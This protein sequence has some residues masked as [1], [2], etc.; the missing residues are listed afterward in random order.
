[1]YHLNITLN[2][3]MKKLA[4]IAASVAMTLAPFASQAATTNSFSPGDLIKGSGAAVYYF[5]AD[6]HR[7][8]FPNA[9]TYFTWYKDFSGVKQIPDSMLASLPLA[10]QNVTYRPGRKM[11]KITTDPSV[12]VV[13]RGGVLR[14]VGSEQLAQTLYGLSWKSNVD[15]VADAFFVNYR[16]GTGIDMAQDYKPAD[17]MTITSTIAQD[18]G[19]DDTKATVTIG[20]TQTGFVPATM[21]VK[22]G[23]TVTWTNSDLA[24][25]TVSGSGWASSG[26]STDQTYSHTFPSTGSFDYKDVGSSM[27]GTINVIP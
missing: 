8:V 13:D 12:Y 9:Q 7:Y 11:V 14:H 6:G 17:V 22:K 19:L 1:M 4:L 27:Q 24:T 23:T 18:K 25:H 2:H 3:S 10:R 5:A 15:D 21:T 20:T 26:L 16:I